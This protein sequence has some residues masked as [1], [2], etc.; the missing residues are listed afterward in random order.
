MRWRDAEIRAPLA[1]IE[2]WSASFE[3]T[4]ALERP[5][6]LVSRPQ[7]SDFCKVL[8]FRD[9]SVVKWFQEWLGVVDG[10][11]AEALRQAGRLQREYGGRR[12]AL[13]VRACGN[14]VCRLS[15]TWGRLRKPASCRLFVLV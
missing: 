8:L 14:R 13:I 6:Y 2:A 5:D 3:G 1:R 4:E 9:T 7:R 10:G 12:A 15:E 11:T